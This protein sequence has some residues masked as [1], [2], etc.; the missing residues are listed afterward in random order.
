MMS[1]RDLWETH[2]QWWQDE[3]TEGAD[4]EYVEQIIPLA[5]E[6]LAGAQR[7]LD[8]GCGEGQIARVAQRAG[9]QFVLG[10]DPTVAQLHEASR[11]AGGP[12]YARAEASALPCAD[13]SFD[14]AVACLVFEHIVDVDSAIAEVGRVLG[15]GGRFLFFL[16]HPLLQTPGSGWI[17]DHILDPPEQ[18]WRIGPYLVESIEIEEIAKDVHLPYVHRPLSRY[19]NALSAAGLFIRQM[20]EPAPPPGFLDRA[21]E[22]GD[23]ATIPRLL[24]LHCERS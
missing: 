24:F 5:T 23:A 15:P 12:R 11:R 3:F 9:A 17:D 7:V 16:N 8:I 18:Y 20:H 1:D 19:V 4:P 6:H 22:Y 10:V 14:A 2:A 21:P 13:A